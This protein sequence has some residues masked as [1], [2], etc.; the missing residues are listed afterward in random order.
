MM[1][2]CHRKLPWGALLSPPSDVPRTDLGR[3][4]I[5]GGGRISALGGFGSATNLAAVGDAIL[6]GRSERQNR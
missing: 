5:L 6:T 4:S 2:V 3:L 1:W